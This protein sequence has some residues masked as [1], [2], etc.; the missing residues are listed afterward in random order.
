MPAEKLVA[1]NENEQLAVLLSRCSGWKVCAF[2]KTCF[3]P[4]KWKLPAVKAK[5]E[6]LDFVFGLGLCR[7]SR[8][9]SPLGQ[10]FRLYTSV[11]SAPELGHF[12]SIHGFS[13]P[14]FWSTHSVLP[15]NECT[16]TKEVLVVEFWGWLSIME[17]GISLRLVNAIKIH[18]ENKAHIWKFLK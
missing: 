11:H 12:S 8:F 4:C 9:Y 3:C 13:S 17:H 1:V 14:D 7:R 10:F 16:N 15:V 6:T 5:R 18:A 2:R